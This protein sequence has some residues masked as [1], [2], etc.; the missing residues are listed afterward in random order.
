MH[1]ST[2]LSRGWVKLTV[3][4][5]VI[6]AMSLPAVAL[7]A[8]AGASPS[9]VPYNCIA[10]GHDT[11]C[12]YLI[13]VGSGGTATVS[14]E[15]QPPYDSGEADDV[16]VGIVNDSDALVTSIQI[17]GSVGNDV[18]NFD[19]D[20]LCSG[21]YNPTP[22]YCSSDSIGS[23]DPYDYEG[24]D[25]TFTVTDDNDGTVNFTTP[26]EPAGATFFSLEDSPFTTGTVGL[27]SAISVAGQAVTGT[28]GTPTGAVVV[29]T[30]NDGPDSSPTTDFTAS[31]N[32]G[33]GSTS[34]STTITQPG[35]SGSAYDVVDNHTYQQSGTYAT[36]VTVS[37]NALPTVNYGIGANSA[38]IADAALMP[39]ATQPTIPNATTAKS[40]TAPV[41]TFVDPNPFATS[42]SGYSATID[43]NDGSTSPGA[44]TE[45][46]SSN[47]GI[48]WEVSGTHTYGA[49]GTYDITV[50]ITDMGGTTPP[51]HSVLTI[52][53]T[54]SDYD[55][56]ITCTS[57]CSGSATQNGQTT[58]AS[59]SSS[60]GTILL[61]LN[62]TPAVVGAFSCG[63]PFRHAALY[64]YVDSTGLSSGSVELTITFAN[65][66]AAGPWYDPFAV[67]YDSPGVAFT[68]IVGKSVTLGL[69][70]FCPLPRKG[71]TIVG[72]CV[73]TIDYSTIIP[74]P[75]E[76]GT[77]TEQLILPPNDPFSH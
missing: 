46:G 50:T 25:N 23:G 60:T 63:D 52:Y 10:V 37:D 39:T 75:S 44:L 41:A 67:C 15:L 76:K 64:S 28:E 1:L 6:A 20:G 57:S 70:P 53:N 58:G 30:F 4:V 68:N 55:A 35:G 31:T 40:F 59:S 7:S 26:L 18:F 54:V 56:V 61:D 38:T 45:L 5:G 12:G 24:P 49:N 71:Q 42:A 29:A 43:W 66:A 19:G 47:A 3:S 34:I 77:V 27:E 48:E 17:S 13:T 33:D 65:S 72:P 62:Q 2:K 69:L 36:S 51:A 22:S 9:A 32:W 11:G 21:D 73:Q 16:L 8:S 74:L 14:R